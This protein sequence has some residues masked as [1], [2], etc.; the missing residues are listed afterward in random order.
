MT[1]GDGRRIEQGR[2]GA[3]RRKTIKPKSRYYDHAW[4]Q[5]SKRWLA[6]H[7][8]CEWCGSRD[9]L[10]VD[11]IVPLR[12]GG[13]KLDPDNLQPLCRSCNNEK[14]GDDRRGYSLRIG[15]DGVPLDPRH[16]ARRT[17]L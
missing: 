10:T 13:A 7:D 16:P 9:D 14:Q 8:I 5:M 1:R 4:Q 15:A 12:L 17:L 2:F 11:H 6:G 3:R